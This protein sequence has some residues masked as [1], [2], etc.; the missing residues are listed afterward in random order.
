MRELADEK[1]VFHSHEEI[2]VRPRDD[3]RAARDE[4]YQDNKKTREHFLSPWRRFMPVARAVFLGQ[5]IR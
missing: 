5:E 4:E 3:R 2:A 1:T